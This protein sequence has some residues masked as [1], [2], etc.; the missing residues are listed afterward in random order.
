MTA[1]IDNHTVTLLGL[2]FYLRESVNNS[3]FRCLLILEHQQILLMILNHRT[4]PIGDETPHGNSVIYTTEQ[5]VDVGVLIM[6]DADEK[7]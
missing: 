3:R 2:V 1:I 5:V 6:V 4:P 7:T